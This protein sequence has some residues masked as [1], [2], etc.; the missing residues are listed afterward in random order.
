M[1]ARIPSP[2]RLINLYSNYI[3]IS[4][5]LSTHRITQK[6][7]QDLLDEIRKLR[8]RVDFLERRA[9]EDRHIIKQLQDSERKS[10]AWLECSPTC[11]KIV[12]L[13]FNL[14]YMSNTG[15]EA[16]HIDNIKPYYRKS[17]PF[18][19]YPQLFRATAIRRD[20]P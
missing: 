19:F 4:E 6:Q 13:D 9:S 16:L 14:Q 8:E 15:V 1:N 18:E 11:T 3:L 20:T 12:D 2:A 7:R 10:H 17:Y 5:H